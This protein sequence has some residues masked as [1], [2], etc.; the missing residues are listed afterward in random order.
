MQ[1]LKFWLEDLYKTAYK[2]HIIHLAVVESFHISEGEVLEYANW[3]TCLNR[4][5]V[6]YRPKE[7][8]SLS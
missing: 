1:L 2:S 7:I 5:T 8:F 3:C 4:Y 6:V